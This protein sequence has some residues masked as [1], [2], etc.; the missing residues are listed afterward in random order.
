MVSQRAP[1]HICLFHT[2]TAL[3]LPCC[4]PFPNGWEISI[5][6]SMEPQTEG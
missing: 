6:L 5:G 2:Q 3:L 4:Q 1:C